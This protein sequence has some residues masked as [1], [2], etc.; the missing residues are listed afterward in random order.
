M[1]VAG[2]QYLVK[3]GLPPSSR[4]PVR[5]ASGRTVFSSNVA[6][7]NAA[8]DRFARNYE[9]R[10]VAEDNSEPA[11]YTAAKNHAAF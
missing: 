7:P 5:V 3:I 11:R 1:S 8:P 2:V 10:G 9:A 6:P 4:S